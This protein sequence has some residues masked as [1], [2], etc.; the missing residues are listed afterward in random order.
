MNISNFFTRFRAKPAEPDTSRVAV[1]TSDLLLAYHKY[2]SSFTATRREELKKNPYVYA[3]IRNTRDELISK[4]Y[5][6]SGYKADS[7]LSENLDRQPQI[8]AAS[9]LPEHEAQANHLRWNIDYRLKRPWTQVLRQLDCAREDGKAVLEILWRRQSDG[10]YKGTW[11]VDD[12]IHCDPDCFTFE[13]VRQTDPLTGECT[14][15]RQMLYDKNAGMRGQPVSEG[16][17][18]FMTFDEERERANGRSILERLAVYDWYQRNN[19]VFWMVHLN[20]YG[21]P[22]LIGKYPR[23]S[24]KQV[25]S[26]LLSAISSFQQETGIVIPDDQQIDILQAQQRDGSGFEKLNNIVVKIISEVITGNAMSLEMPEIGT[27]AATKATTV[28]IRQIL[29]Y[30]RAVSVDAVIN[31]QLIPY[32]MGYNYPGAVIFP[33]QQLLPPQAEMIY[34][35]TAAT[36]DV[37]MTEAEIKGFAEQP[38]RP[39]DALYASA[40]AKS[41]RVLEDT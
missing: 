3:A 19:F 28:D 11:V 36:G 26:R 17:F 32:F 23:G 30:A 18:I 33:H 16:K 9:A 1:S 39:E 41:F 8:L 4:W 38:S 21:S 40:L 5:G 37:V 10:P 2:D 24:G 25:I 34:N 7:T 12:L 15:I 14:Y 29:L 31:R 35:P 27:Y 20:R 13:Y 6:A 22:G